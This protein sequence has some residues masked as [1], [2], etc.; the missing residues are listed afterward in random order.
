M[1]VQG[2]F[3]KRNFT[4]LFGPTE[5]VPIV[6]YFGFGRKVK[7]ISLSPRAGIFAA[8]CDV[9]VTPGRFELH[10]F[11]GPLFRSHLIIPTEGVPPTCVDTF[12]GE[13]RIAWGDSRGRAVS[14]GNK[15]P[16][17]TQEFSHEGAITG[18]RFLR[19]GKQMVT[20]GQG[21]ISI[22]ELD[23]GKRA[24]RYV[25]QGPYEK[26]V[27]SETLLLALTSNSGGLR[28]IKIDV[29]ILSMPQR[30]HY[31]P[32][33]AD[34]S[35]SRDGD[36]LATYGAGQDIIVY[37]IDRSTLNN[38]PPVEVR[39]IST[40]VEGQSIDL[41]K[42]VVAHDPVFRCLTLVLSRGKVYMDDGRS[43]GVGRLDRIEH[44]FVDARTILDISD[45]SD[46]ALNALFVY[47]ERGEAKAIVWGFVG[48]AHLHRRAALPYPH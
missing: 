13:M 17:Y 44:P 48:N 16:T 18:I 36:I 20:Y 19:D 15:P 8:I 6:L 9:I 30:I 32:A 11:S 28:R 42:V 26:A 2:Q 41:K 45:L 38:T 33:Q 46:D 14:H 34:F 3:H 25:I 21:E 5:K 12:D 47:E 10:K 40:V 35:I 29:N 7:Q 37:R 23:T 43:A 27:V 4:K 39:R 1:P 22:Q 24:A 31:L